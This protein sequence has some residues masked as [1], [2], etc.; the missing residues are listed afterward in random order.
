VAVVLHPFGFSEIQMGVRGRVFPDEC[1]VGGLDSHDVTG[2]LVWQHESRRF[3]GQLTHRE[4]SGTCS[5]HDDRRGHPH[6]ASVQ[7]ED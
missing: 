6:D 3:P 5:D 7:I 2:N 1:E 4:G